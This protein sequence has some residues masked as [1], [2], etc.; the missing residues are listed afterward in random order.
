MEKGHPLDKLYLNK[1]IINRSDY[2]KFIVSV[3]LN[4]LNVLIDYEN[5]NL[6]HRDIKPANIYLANGKVKIGDFDCSTINY[7]RTQYQTS[8]VSPIYAAPETYPN[9]IKAKYGSKS[10]VFSIAVAI[11]ITLNKGEL[12]GVSK[13]EAKEITTNQLRL[14]DYNL[15]RHSPKFTKEPLINK[16]D[17]LNHILLKGLRYDPR[18]RAT[19]IEFARELEH[20]L[21]TY[22]NY[23]TSYNWSLILLIGLL[24]SILVIFIM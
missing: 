4:A 5:K 19:M 6:L 2:K 8:V 10:Q 23:Q 13:K 16:N 24:F 14:N 1:N 12:I 3:Y 9:K 20:Y 7:S 18:F 11:A 17:S 15:N 22:G 21:A